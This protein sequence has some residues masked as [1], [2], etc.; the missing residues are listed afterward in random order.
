MTWFPP[1][2]S[3]FCFGCNEDV[4]DMSNAYLVLVF[5]ML[6]ISGNVPF[7]TEMP[8][9]PPPSPLLLA[10]TVTNGATIIHPTRR[11][12]IVAMGKRRVSDNRNVAPGTGATAP[13]TANQGM[14]TPSVPAQQQRQRIRQLQQQQQQQ[15]QQQQQQSQH[16]QQR[17]QQQQ[18]QQQQQQ[19]QMM[20]QV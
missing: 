3:S 7:V 19:Q 14:T 12:Y 6:T 13:Q 17:Q 9:P 2:R 8:R 1:A 4:I 5:R 10:R 20:T 15:R 16:Q 11:V 18:P